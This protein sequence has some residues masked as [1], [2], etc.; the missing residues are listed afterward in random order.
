[1]VAMSACGRPAAVSDRPPDEPNA[2]GSFDGF[3]DDPPP[4][5]TTASRTA[6]N[7]TTAR[8]TMTARRGMDLLTYQAWPLVPETTRRFSTEATPGTPL[9]VRST[10]TFA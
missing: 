1:M 8:R 3:F 2:T 7:G 6:S 4:T 5:M 9:A 10:S